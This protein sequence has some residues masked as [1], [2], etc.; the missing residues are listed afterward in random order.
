MF[1][2]AMPDIQLLSGS[3][4]SL[5]GRIRTNTRIFLSPFVLPVDVIELF[6]IVYVFLDRFLYFYI[7][8]INLEI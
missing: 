7:W 1:L 8:F 5:K 2:S 3:Y 4:L 6:D